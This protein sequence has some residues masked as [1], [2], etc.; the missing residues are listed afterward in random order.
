MI[1]VRKQFFFCVSQ[2]N[3]RKGVHILF[4]S[5]FNT[6]ARKHA[7]KDT[8][9]LSPFC[10]Q[11]IHLELV[12]PSVR[13]YS[14]HSP[15]VRLCSTYT[16]LVRLCSTY[17][18]LVRLCSTYTHLVSLC[19]TCTHL[20]RLCST[21]T[22]LVRLCSTYTP[23]GRLCSTYAPLGRRPDMTFAVDWAL[24]NNYLYIYL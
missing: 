3:A 12:C 1:V 23:L 5:V 18:H 6:H 14:T 11:H 21:C 10:V 16:P 8:H 24:N 4:P 15:L 19:S 17:T 13:P 22:H 2:C 9:T 20:V 7:R